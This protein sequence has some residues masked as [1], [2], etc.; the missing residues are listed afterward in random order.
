MGLAFCK[1]YALCE[2]LSRVK[3]S[4]GNIHPAGTMAY[5]IAI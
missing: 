3:V 1:K 4:T 2:G 5:N